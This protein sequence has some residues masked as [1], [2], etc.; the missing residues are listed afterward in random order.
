MKHQIC[1]TVLAAAAVTVGIFLSAC[2]LFRTPADDVFDNAEDAIATDLAAD[3]I[4]TAQIEYKFGDGKTSTVRFQAPESVRIDVL[5]GGNS[6]VF[7]MNGDSGWMYLGG[8]VIDMTKDDL[9]EMHGALLQTIPFRVDFQEIFTDAELED[10]TEDVCGEECKVIEAVFRLEPGIKAKIWIGEDTDLMRQFEI[11]G[12]DGGVYTMQYFDY[13]TFDDDVT[14]PS[15]MFRFTPEGSTKLSLVSY[16]TNVEIPESIF[17][18]PELVN[19]T[20]GDK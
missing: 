3:N 10:E 9:K 19:I 2:G 20:E 8:E 13:A 17:R 18:K 12:E 16:E 11:I 1:R 7:C 15:E 6:A 5:D 14:L 4:K